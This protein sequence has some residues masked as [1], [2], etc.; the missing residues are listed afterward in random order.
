MLD[1]SR[2]TI[3]LAA[4]ALLQQMGVEVYVFLPPFT[5][6]VKATLDTSPTWAT[7][8]RAYHID[9]PARLRAAGIFCLPL[10]VPTQDGFND[11]YMYDGYHPSEI[12][13][14]AIVRQIVQQAPQHSLLRQIDLAY[15][16][17]L[18]SRDHITPLSFEKPPGQFG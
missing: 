10:S 11:T 5:A 8:W 12:Y 1:T 7:F 17:A 9:L 3:L 18:L 4:L 16:H 15:L 13:M 2:V 6:A 14:T